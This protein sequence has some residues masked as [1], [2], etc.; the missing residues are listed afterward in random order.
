MASGRSVCARWSD[1]KYAVYSRKPEAEGCRPPP[2]QWG[3]GARTRSAACSSF[4]QPGRGVTAP[5]PTRRLPGRLRLPAVHCGPLTSKQSSDAKP[6]RWK[7]SH[8]FLGKPIAALRPRT[9]PG[10]RGNRSPLPEQPGSSIT[11]KF[12]RRLQQPPS[13]T[14]LSSP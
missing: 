5:V 1:Q 10:S 3:R 2:N 8:A 4:Q 6:L 12:T 7:P 13:A 14:C 11:C 9:M